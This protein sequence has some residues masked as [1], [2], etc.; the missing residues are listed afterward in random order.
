MSREIIATVTCDQCGAQVSM[1]GTLHPAGL[2]RR[3]A[4]ISFQP[5]F[6]WLCSDMAEA[7]DVCSAICR[8]KWEAKMVGLKVVG[9]HEP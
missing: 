5:P 6:G 8:V 1:V 9:E 2:V 3:D 4:W 7:V